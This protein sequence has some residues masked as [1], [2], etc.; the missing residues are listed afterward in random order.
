MYGG[1]HIPDMPE[2]A[3]FYLLFFIMAVAAVLV[4][5]YGWGLK[6]PRK[7]TW[8]PLQVILRH[9]LLPAFAAVCANACAMLYYARQTVAEIAWGLEAYRHSAEAYVLSQWVVPATWTVGI[10]AAAAALLSVVCS[11]LYDRRN[12]FAFVRKTRREFRSFLTR[13][14]RG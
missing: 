9:Q 7:K 8:N 5:L 4:C 12:G 2:I 13:R 1:K 11:V 10:V 14:K 6:D 3:L